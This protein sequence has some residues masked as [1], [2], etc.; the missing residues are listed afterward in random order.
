MPEDIQLRERVKELRCLYNVTVVSHEIEATGDYLRALP[1]LIVPGWF[2]PEITVVRVSYRGQSF[3]TE[4]YRDTPWR[5]LA[6]LL[7]QGREVG[8]IEVAYL[9]ERPEQ[10]EGPFLAEERELLDALATHVARTLQNREL[11][12]R[13]RRIQRLEALGFLAGGVAHDFNNFLSVISMLAEHALIKEG[14]GEQVTADIKEILTVAERSRR[15]ADRLVGFAGTDEEPTQAVSFNAVLTDCRGILGRLLSDDVELRLDLDPDLRLVEIGP[16]QLDQVL[17]NLAINAREAMPDG[18]LFEIVTRNLPKDKVLLACQD[19]GCGIPEEVLS[20]LFEPFFSTKLDGAGLGLAT[21][22]DIVRGVG[23]EVGVQSK[24]G[25]GTRF[26]LVFPAHRV[27]PS[28]GAT[29]PQSAT[30]ATVLLVEG[31]AAVRYLCERLLVKMG[32]Q[33]ISAESGEDALRMAREN[34]PDID[35]LV[36]DLLLP[37]MPGPELARRLDWPRTRTLLMSGCSQEVVGEMA[38]GYLCLPKPFTS[39]LLRKRIGELL[40]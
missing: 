20:R 5:L 4:G 8:A 12:Q 30:R 26:E 33:V 21:V 7:F 18:G 37:D 39:E 16:T 11:E 6:P 2:Y 28:A 3:H 24:K 17:A 40:P 36:T 35:L 10:Q 32:C 9:E 31:E 15:L 13:L 14:R 38:Q 1:G 19:T 22:E 29:E 25:E 34:G 27:E 23:G